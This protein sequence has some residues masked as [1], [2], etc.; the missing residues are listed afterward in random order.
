[1]HVPKWSKMVFILLVGFETLLGIVHV[2]AF[3]DKQLFPK[4]ESGIKIISDHF[5]TGMR[6]IILGAYVS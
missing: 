5:G 1:M 2:H 6:A 4:C 3:Y